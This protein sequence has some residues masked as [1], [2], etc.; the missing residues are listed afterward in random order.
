MFPLSRYLD[1]S[2]EKW[3]N[4]HP[5]WTVSIF[6]KL[7]SRECYNDFVAAEVTAIDPPDMTPVGDNDASDDSFRKRTTSRFE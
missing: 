6:M 7:Y 2:L 1:Q 3:L 5:D 4:N